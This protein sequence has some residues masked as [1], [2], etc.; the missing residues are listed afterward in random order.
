MNRMLLL[1]L[2]LLILSPV[3]PA[4]STQPDTLHFK[5]G[6]NLVTLRGQAQQVWFYPATGIN[7]HHKILFA[8]GDGGH[9]GFAITIAEQL[10]ALGYDVYALDTR[11]YL[12]SFTGKTPLLPTDVMADFHSLALKIR[13]QADERITL[14]GWSTGAGLTVLAAADKNKA[15]YDGLLAISLGKTNILGWHWSDNLAT[16]FGKTPHEATF[17]SVEF[18]PQI[19]PLP[20]FIIQSSR[21]EFIPKEDAEYL[22]VRTKRPKRFRLIHANNHSFADKR[23]EFFAAAQHGLQWIDGLSRSTPATADR[24]IQFPSW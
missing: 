19:A 4:Q 5:V 13:S 23:E 21:D 3:V 9:R 1:L 15:G 22:F 6:R 2:C 10:S 7:L 11:H 20:V 16:W 14:A 12:A 17:Q 8:P 18:V 24:A